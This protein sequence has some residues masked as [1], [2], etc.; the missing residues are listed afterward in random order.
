MRFGAGIRSIFNHLLFK[1]PALPRAWCCPRMRKELWCRA[2]VLY[3][4]P[5]RRTREQK[6]GG[7]NL[8]TESSRG[9]NRTSFTVPLCPGNLYNIF[10]LAASQITAVPSPLPQ[11]ILCPF[12]SQL[13]LIRFCSNPMGA[14]AYDLR[15]RSVGAKGR[16]SHVRAKPSK[17]YVSRTCASGE[18][19][20]EVTVSVCP[21]I[22]YT[23]ACLR[24]SHTLMSLSIPPE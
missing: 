16:M 9:E 8:L 10:P 6:K 20:R 1:P 19:S 21:G 2:S 17:E 7:L 23:T 5:R 22:V 13:A 12:I 3:S 15:E 11:Q 14:P 24:I 18:T 4:P